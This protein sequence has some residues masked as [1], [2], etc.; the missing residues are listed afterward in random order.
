MCSHRT[1]TLLLC[2]GSFGGFRTNNWHNNKTVTV[3][4]L[5]LLRVF[6]LQPL[7]TGSKRSQ[8]NHITVG[9]SRQ[10]Q[11]GLGFAEEVGVSSWS[12]AEN[13]ACT[14][15]TWL[16][17][18]RSPLNQCHWSRGI[19]QGAPPRVSVNNSWDMSTRHV[20]GWGLPRRF[21]RLEWMWLA[22]RKDGSVQGHEGCV[23]VSQ[24]PRVFSNLPAPHSF[25][26]FCQ[27]ILKD[28]RPRLVVTKTEHSVSKEGQICMHRRHNMSA[29]TDRMWFSLRLSVNECRP[30][31]NSACNQKH[32]KEKMPFCR[33]TSSCPWKQRQRLKCSRR[34][35]RVLPTNHRTPRTRPIYWTKE[36]RYSWYE[37]KYMLYYPL[38]IAFTAPARA[39][40]Y[41][42]NNSDYT[43][44]KWRHS[45]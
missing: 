15:M 44:I 31:L 16:L 43:L 18:I 7:Y 30:G 2:C 21:S 12:T 29:W 28:N 34:Q 38:F 13:H 23:R 45:R 37:W 22:Q 19:T 26:F 14:S 11:S 42:S 33:F 8:D 10:K 32:C 5:P 3:S 20:N 17:R 9:R 35:V 1:R 36:W 25:P 4:P 39:W 40:C 41:D 6:L 24:S 27:A